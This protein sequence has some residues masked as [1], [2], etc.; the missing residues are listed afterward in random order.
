MPLKVQGHTVP[1][2]KAL[3]SDKLEPRGLRCGSTFI[4]CYVL[5]KTAILLHTE[6]LV[7]TEIV[8]RVMLLTVHSKMAVFL[9]KKC[10]HTLALLAPFYHNSQLSNEALYDLVP[11]EALE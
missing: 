5:L 7:K 11:Q 6:G 3:I 9:R 1:H 4:L 8:C 2:W 10:C